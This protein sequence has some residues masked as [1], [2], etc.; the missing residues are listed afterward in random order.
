MKRVPTT[1]NQDVVYEYCET[2][3]NSDKS[4]LRSKLRVKEG[5]ILSGLLF[6]SVVRSTGSVNKRKVSCC[7]TIG[8]C[9]G[10]KLWVKKGS[11][12]IP[13]AD[14]NHRF[15]GYGTAREGREPTRSTILDQGWTL[16]GTSTIL[17]QGWTLVST[18]LD[19]GWTLWFKEQHTW[20]DMHGMAPQSRGRAFDKLA[21]YATIRRIRKT[22]YSPW[23][24][25]KLKFHILCVYPDSRKKI[26]NN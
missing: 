2:S 12:H 19:Q 21:A 13:S 11:K 3:P 5:L 7:E 15:V 26:P 24:C 1:T 6:L 9:C 10:T 18:I 20:Q 23:I 4:R 8:K 14:N 25:G 17:D 22:A 16:L